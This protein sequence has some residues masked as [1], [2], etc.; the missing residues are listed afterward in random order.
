M[1]VCVCVHDRHLIQENVSGQRVG[2]VQ[3]FPLCRE[4]TFYFSHQRRSH[5][6]GELLTQELP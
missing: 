4:H 6:S 2:M 5:A 3:M 1:C